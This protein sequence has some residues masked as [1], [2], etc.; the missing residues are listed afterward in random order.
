MERGAREKECY[1]AIVLEEN[2]A[3]ATQELK[4]AEG[5]VLLFRMLH[6]KSAHVLKKG[7]DVESAVICL[8]QLF[9]FASSA[10][11]QHD[12]QS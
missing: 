1:L 11:R 3:F 12:G 10:D 9:Y 5:V 2:I 7:G 4:G 8:G 6:Q